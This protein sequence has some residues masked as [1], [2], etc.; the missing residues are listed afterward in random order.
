[1]VSIRS[2]AA[3]CSGAKV[4]MPS[5][6]TFRP[7]SHIVSPMENMPGVE[8]A[9]DVTGIR[10]VDNGAL[11]RHELLR[12]REAQGLSALHVPILPVAL[13]SAGAYAHERYPVAVRL[14]HI[15]LY[16]ENERGKMRVKRVNYIIAGYSGQGAAWSCAESFQKRLTPK[17]LSA[18]PKNTGLSFPERTF[19][20]SKS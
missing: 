2:T 5:N 9:D 7:F 13:K 20:I 12:L 18:E 4:G 14:V 3:K 6:I 17:L 11:L 10:L 19:S 16:L 15:R 8:H 1:M